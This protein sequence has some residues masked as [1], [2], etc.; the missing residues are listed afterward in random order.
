MDQQ[1]PTRE[2]FREGV[3]RVAGRRMRN[4]S[5]QHLGKPQHLLKQGG[6][7]QHL[8]PQDARHNPHPYTGHLDHAR[9]R[10]RVLKPISAAQPTNPSLPMTPASID[11]PSSRSTTND[12]MP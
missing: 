2:P 7:A 1:Q 3:V 9:K 6:A 11:A 10:G 12:V 4:P 5:A 8:L